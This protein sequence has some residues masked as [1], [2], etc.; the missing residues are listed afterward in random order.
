MKRAIFILFIFILSACASSPK[1]N[2]KFSDFI[3][4]RNQRNNL[5]IL[6]IDNT[7]INIV[8]PD[9]FEPHPAN[10]QRN[11]YQMMLEVLPEGKSFSNFD[12][13]ITVVNIFVDTSIFNMDFYLESFEKSMI[14][15][16][17]CDNRDSKFEI[18][19]KS[20]DEAIYTLKCGKLVKGK[21]DRQTGN[22]GEVSI[23]RSYL[24]GNQF[25][26]VIYNF[27]GK[28]FDID[29][30]KT[31]MTEKDHK[32]FYLMTNDTIICD[33]HQKSETCKILSNVKPNNFKDIRYTIPEGYVPDSDLAKKYNVDDLIIAAGE[34]PEDTKKPLIIIKYFDKKEKLRDS[35]ARRM[36]EIKTT[37]KN[38]KTA[39]FQVN[40]LDLY[41]TAFISTGI[42]IPNPK[43]DK[44]IPDPYDF[45]YIETK[46]KFILVQI[47]VDNEKEMN[48]K[49][50]NDFVNSIR[51][52]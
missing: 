7:L 22:Q 18:I 31:P 14:A 34:T 19:S 5:T 48:S 1:N 29:G 11:A 21:I 35:Y 9:D 42:I 32:E 40:N 38:Y 8:M 43:N 39:P 37:F 26:T 2:T 33:K 25:I 4:D 36:A 20:D 49:F 10:S 47:I 13:L 51:L 41:R 6:G 3:D 52:Y 45:L 46:D 24:R 12:K 50:V 27:R 15:D 23:F 44:N 16:T 17:S 30:T 28:T